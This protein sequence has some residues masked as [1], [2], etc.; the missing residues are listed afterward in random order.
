MSQASQTKPGQGRPGQGRPGQGRP[1]N[2][3][4]DRDENL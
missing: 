1:K 3:P 2:K 4:E